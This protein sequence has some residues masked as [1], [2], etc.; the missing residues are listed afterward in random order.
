MKQIFPH[1]LAWL[2]HNPLRKLLVTPERLTDRLPLRPGS[3]VLEL[4]PGSGFF[5]RE[6]AGRIPGGRLTLVDIQWQMLA[7]A[8]RI[9]DP[10]K[11]ANVDC[12]VADG[13]G[14]LPFRSGHFDLALLVAVLGEVSDPEGCLDALA[15]V[16]KPGGILAIHEH[17]P[18]PDW[19]S[20][21]RLRAMVP[22][23][24]FSLLESLG[25]AWNYTAIFLRTDGQGRPIG[26][27]T[28]S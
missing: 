14:A 8:R 6:I 9:L 28:R 3:R 25:P 12:A 10:G 21:R 4:G 27:V 7:K 11:T 22:A 13:G 1:W 15:N 20:P 5:S 24:G 2:L 16:I 26:S 17:L 18:D 23:H 19:I